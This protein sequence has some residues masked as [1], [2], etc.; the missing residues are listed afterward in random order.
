RWLVKLNEGTN[1]LRAVGHAAGG[2]ISD[3]IALEYQAAQWGNPVK[4]TL[5]EVSQTNGVATLEARVFDKDNVP[6]LDAANVVRFGL[7]GDGRL[8]DDLGTV[9]GSR[10]VQLSN[11]RAQISVRLTARK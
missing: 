1:T 5:K 7:T 4:L 8:L 11:G 2:D 10:V 6:C 3:A 9:D